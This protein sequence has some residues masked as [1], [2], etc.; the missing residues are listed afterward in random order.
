MSKKDTTFSSS[1]Q[2]PRGRGKSFKT[3]LLEVIREESLI[4]ASPKTTPEEAE[5]LY[6]THFA[7]RAF[8]VDDN[9][10]GTLGKELLSKSYPS[11]KSTMPTVDF[12]FSAESTPLEQANQI[13]KAAADGIIPPDVAQIFITSIASM[14]KIDEI[15]EIAN[16]LTAIEKELGINA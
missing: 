13:L 8:D 12:E 5:K 16:R 10:S 3:K 6:L 7:K 11:L 2:P 4:G 14:M 1:N 15:T 9:A